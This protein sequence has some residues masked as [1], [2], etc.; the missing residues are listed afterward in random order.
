MTDRF[1]GLV[2]TLEQ[3]MRDDDAA[4]LIDAIRQLRGVAAVEACAV[5]AVDDYVNQER[6]KHEL[7]Q[8]LLRILE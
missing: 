4:G 2:V 6:A 8:Q 5:R 3:D 7:R 1:K